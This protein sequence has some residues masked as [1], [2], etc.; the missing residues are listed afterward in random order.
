MKYYHLSLLFINVYLTVQ[1]GRKTMEAKTTFKQRIIDC[2]SDAGCSREVCKACAECYEKE[3]LGK[4]LS[5][6]KCERKNL[7]EKLAKVQFELDTLD[8][9]IRIVEQRNK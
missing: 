7:R 3:E 2:L 5:Q 1:A 4:M 9:L 6:I 8:F